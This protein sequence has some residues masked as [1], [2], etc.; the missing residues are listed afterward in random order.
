MASMASISLVDPAAMVPTVLA[1][2]LAP[3]AGDSVPA[4]W[5]IETAHPPVF[6]PKIMLVSRPNAKKDVR[7]VS[8][9]IEVPY[10]VV[11]TASPLP[12]LVSTPFLT[13]E[14]VVPQ[15]TD[16]GTID[17]LVAYAQSFI[18]SSLVREVLRTQI[19]PT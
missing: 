3:S 8:A 13:F 4:Q 6:R 18:G 17:N 7:R 15:I 14:L 19:A 5:R 11:G 12:I 16:N 10:V 1:A 2:A 9:K